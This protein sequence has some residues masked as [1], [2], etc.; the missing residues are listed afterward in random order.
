VLEVIGLYPAT[1]PAE[2]EAV[3]G[4][5]LAKALL[6]NFDFP[7]RLPEDEEGAEIAVPAGVGSDSVE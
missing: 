5:D 6:K 1:A 3:E 7:N 2:A 4:D